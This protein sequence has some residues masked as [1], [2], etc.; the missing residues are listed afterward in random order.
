MDTLRYLLLVNGLLVV[1]SVSYY[2]LL[3]RETFFRVNR[4]V[5]WLGILA[6][7]ALPLLELPDWRPQPVQQAMRQTAQVIRAERFRQPDLWQPVTS[8]LQTDTPTSVTSVVERS[9]TDVLLLIY[10]IV[11]A[12]LLI[13][14]CI[15]LL[16]LMR[17]VRRSV[18]EPYDDFILVSSSTV[19][20]PFS[21]FSWVFINPARHD[22]D[23]SAHILR[24][25]RVHVRQNHSLDMI[26]AELLCCLLWFNPAIYL[27]RY[28]LHQILEFIADRAVLD[29]GVDARAYQYSLLRVSLAGGQ[30]SVTN[31]FNKSQLKTRIAMIARSR[32]SLFTA[33]KYPVAGLIVLVVTVAF[34]RPTVTKETIVNSVVVPK[35]GN[36]FIT[37]T[38]IAA[39]SPAVCLP[40]SGAYVVVEGEAVTPDSIRKVSET[41]PEVPLKSRLLVKQGNYVYWIV[42]PK[43]TLDDFA[44]L[45][46]EL[47]RYG[48]T[49]QLNEVK[50]DPM[51]TYIDRLIFTIVRSSGGLTRI[52]ETDDDFAPIPTVSGYIGV[53]TQSGEAGTGQLKSIDKD[54]F[55]KRS[56]GAP[57][58][59]ALRQIAANDE[60]AIAKFVADHRLDYLIHEGEQKFAQNSGRRAFGKAFF[61]NESIKTSGLNRQDDGNLSVNSEFLLVPLYINNQPATLTDVTVLTVDQLYSVV[62]VTTYDATQKKSLNSALLIYI[63]DKK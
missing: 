29:E 6:A 43:T 57:F 56:T 12:G 38:Q 28:L 62:K 14:F 7:F 37:P 15:Q 58:P 17:L 16:S 61:Q 39:I 35:P 63:D 33:V 47:A 52:T 60:S 41:I 18:H 44:L 40:D 55:W 49:M 2:V 13:R 53:G 23:E 31:H 51:Y 48:N 42:T 36:Q 1:G 10:G 30:S 34:T 26:G 4:L 32:S 11:L 45:K 3:R 27:F 50:Y 21:F 9:W 20:S 8:S 22:P 54:D 59:T 24:H 46:Q 19:Q 25:E 5:L